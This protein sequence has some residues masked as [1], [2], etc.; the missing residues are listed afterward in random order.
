MISGTFSQWRTSSFS[1]GNTN[2]CVE[3]GVAP[4]LRAVRDTKL[5]SASPVLAFSSV[6]WRCFIEELKP[7]AGQ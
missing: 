1:T 7:V 2:S 5:G 6:H 4:Q 3:V